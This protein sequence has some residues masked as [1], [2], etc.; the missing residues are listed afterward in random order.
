MTSAAI[1]ATIVIPMARRCARPPPRFERRQRCR[2]RLAL[3][4][5]A[6]AASA[7]WAEAERH[8]ARRLRLRPG[9]GNKMTVSRIQ[10]H[11]IPS[12]RYLIRA[13]RSFRNG[14]GSLESSVSATSAFSAMNSVPGAN[15][16]KPGAAP[17]GSA[18]GVSPARRRT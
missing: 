8:L 17:A 13:L 18:V 15:S 9:V 5:W 6:P 16:S 10:W 11:R 4:R 12:S 7:A 1:T 3:G 14:A 2:R